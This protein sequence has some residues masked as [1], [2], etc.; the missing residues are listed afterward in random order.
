[1]SKARLAQCKAFVDAGKLREAWDVAEELLTAEPNKANPII[2]A[3]YVLHKMGKSALAYNLALRA[4]HAAPHES[5]AWT[6]L[7]VAAQEL[8]FQDEAEAAY[9][10]GFRLAS[11]DADRA[12]CAMNLSALYIDAGRWKDAESLGREA[13]RYSPLSAKAKA[14]VG[15]GMLGQR[16]WEGWD[17][18]SYSLGL[19]SRRKFKFGDEPDWDGA[20]GKTV[21][22]YGEQG[23]GDELSFASMVPDAVRD[24]EKVII[25]C[26]PK[27]AGLFRR[28]FPRAKVYGTRWAKRGDGA[29]WDEADRRIDASCALGELGKLYRRTDESFTGEP[30]LVADPIRRAMWRSHFADVS[31][32]ESGRHLHIQRRP[33]IGIAWTGGIPRTGEQFR[34]LKLADLVPVLQSVDA[35]WVSLQYKD[36]GAEI[37]EFTR[38]HPEIDI[39]Q[40]PWATLTADYDD[41]A[42]LVAELDLVVAMQTAVC[43]LAG[44]LGK[45]CWVLLPKNSQWRYGSEGE[46][47]P[48][49]ESLRV[50][51]QGKLGEWGPVIG[52]VVGRLRAR[53]GERREEVAA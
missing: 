21:A 25:D 13:M 9:K 42:A 48:W 1:V 31:L 11:D 30:Y 45:E 3:S 20:P 19:E 38:S 16:K 15:F 29:Q 10:T 6:N 22:L 14:N 51:R 17:Y 34:T 12:R 35:H 32:Q 7:G 33:V 4:T 49:Y 2:L 47:I 28:S 37:K 40:Y 8:W 5:A 18:Y 41:T 50:I 39:A 27:L 46:T 23:L 43:H 24:C 36:A 44:A 26:E 53:F 52:E